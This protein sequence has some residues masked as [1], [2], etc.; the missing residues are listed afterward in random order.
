MFSWMFRSKRDVQYSGLCCF[1][2]QSLFSWMF[3]SKEP[4]TFAAYPRTDVSILVLVDV[5]L[6]ACI[7]YTDSVRDFSF[8]PCSRGCSARR[9]LS[10][11]D[12][13]TET[14]FNPC[15]RGCSARRPVAVCMGCGKPMFQSLFSW[16]FRSKS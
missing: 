6:E 15:S 3:R 5:P 13:E 16:M 12:P 9:F 10:P 4:G 1:R 8:N 11:N 2:F 14:G 7:L